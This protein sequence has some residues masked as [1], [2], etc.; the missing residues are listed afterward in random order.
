MG[1]GLL[2]VDVVTERQANLHDEL[3]DLLE[4]ESVFRFPSSAPLYC[5]AYHPRRTAPAGDQIELRRAP[6]ALGNQLP[7]MPLAL[8]GG[9]IVPVDLEGTYTRTRQRTLV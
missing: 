5:V 2:V 3:I 1:I 4:Q 9:P 8:R 7:T 6:L